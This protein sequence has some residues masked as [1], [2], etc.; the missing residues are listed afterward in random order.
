[1][2]T[3]WVTSSFVVVFF[4]FSWHKSGT[5][6]CSEVH[7]WVHGCSWGCGTVEASGAR[8]MGVGRSAPHPAL[9]T[10]LQVPWTFSRARRTLQTSCCNKRVCT[11]KE[12]LS[13]ATA[14]SSFYGLMEEWKKNDVFLS[15]WVFWAGNC[16]WR[17]KKWKINHRDS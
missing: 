16:S 11:K 4:R 17:F 12:I 3:S 5:A 14:A 13:G 2:Q 15:L 8:W 1:M 9:R 6:V 7:E 10:P